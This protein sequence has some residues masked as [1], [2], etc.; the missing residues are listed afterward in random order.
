MKAKLGNMQY[1]VVEDD[2][3]AKGLKPS[4]TNRSKELS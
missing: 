2:E 4:A 3:V 1:A